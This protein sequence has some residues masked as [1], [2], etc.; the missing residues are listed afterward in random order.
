M[1]SKN[2]SIDKEQIKALNVLKN[3]ISKSRKLQNPEIF[4]ETMN[5]IKK[6]AETIPLLYIE[7]ISMTFYQIYNN[8][9]IKKPNQY[10]KKVIKL[11]DLMILNFN[12]ENLLNLI[13]NEIDTNFSDYFKT[14]KIFDDEK[15]EKDDLEICFAICV[16]SKNITLMKLFFTEYLKVSLFTEEN[17]IS[18]N[19]DNLY[20][21][22]LFDTIFNKL[23]NNKKIVQSS[24]LDSLVQYCIEDSNESVFKM[25]RCD[26]CYDI[27]DI[28][29]N[30][31]NNFDTRCLNCSK[32]Y[33]SYKEFDLNNTIL[34]NFKCS[35]CKN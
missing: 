22:K 32:K 24:E 11:A 10:V 3:E 30:D 2:S 31:K 26:K 25:F 29:L 6:K 28:K 1:K 4:N 35:I 34:L 16:I 13:Q 23:Y 17:F 15:R 33:K 12:E 27:M 8:L 19:F 7:K 18:I 5:D 14:F 9:A 21:L 20:A